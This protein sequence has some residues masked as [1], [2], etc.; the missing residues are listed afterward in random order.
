MH[1]G[2]NLVELGDGE[3]I[4]GTPCCGSLLDGTFHGD[5]VGAHLSLQAEDVILDLDE[6]L[7]ALQLLVQEAQV[8]ADADQSLHG[9]SGGL[10]LWGH[11]PL[12][13]QVRETACESLGQSQLE[14]TLTASRTLVR[15]L[16]MW[17]W[18]I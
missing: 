11:W 5:G 7:H 2:Q 10:C 15:R 1:L 17:T 18:V 13:A 8:V 12:N 4:S 6:H 3:A 9:R 16:V 14:R